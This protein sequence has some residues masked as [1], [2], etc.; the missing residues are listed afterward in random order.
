VL[1]KRDAGH[2]L[3]HRPKDREVLCRQSCRA[4]AVEYVGA[5]MRMFAG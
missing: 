5:V 1:A 4:N 3:E 2:G